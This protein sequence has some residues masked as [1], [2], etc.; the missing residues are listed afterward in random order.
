[1]YREFDL[2]Y[3][4]NLMTRE[5]LSCSESFFEIPPYESWIDL[6]IENKIPMIESLDN[7]QSI[8]FVKNGKIIRRKLSP[9]KSL[10]LRSPDFSFKSYS[11]AKSHEPEK[12]FW[13]T[14]ILSKIPYTK[15][16]IETLPFDKIGVVRVFLTEN[17]FL[18]T[19]D[20]KTRILKNNLGISLVPI[21][22]GVPLIIFDKEHCQSYPVFSSS[23]IFDDFNLHGIPMVDG[24]RIDIRV[25]GEFRNDFIQNNSIC[26]HTPSK[27]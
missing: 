11:R 5:I 23:F 7:Y 26:Y 12:S 22:S 16:I 10:Y 9:P 6:A 18:P 3:D 4:K 13:N 2:A 27:I 19:H 8:T 17:T 25:F 21:D 15:K 24:I 1:M 20:D 14:E